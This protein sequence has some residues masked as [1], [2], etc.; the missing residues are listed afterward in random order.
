[1]ISK[2]AIRMANS[3]KERKILRLKKC[4]KAVKKVAKTLKIEGA[5]YGLTTHA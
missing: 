3:Q 5:S 2:S 4:R 1:M